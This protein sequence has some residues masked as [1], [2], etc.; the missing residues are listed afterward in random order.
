M[1]AT[2]SVPI[3]DTVDFPGSKDDIRARLFATLVDLLA[4][5]R[6]YGLARLILGNSSDAEDA[7]HDA[8]LTA[9]RRFADLR[10]PDRFEAWFGRILDQC[11]SRSATRPTPAAD[12]RDARGW[13]IARRSIERSGRRVVRH[14]V[15]RRAVRSLSAEHRE[16]VVLRYYADL[17]VDQ[18]AERTG[19]RTGTVKSLIH[20]THF[21]ECAPR[22]TPVAT[23]GPADER[24]EA[25]PAVT[26]V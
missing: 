19:T 12:Q 2:D 15:L 18:I 5:D 23:G 4:L 16:V 13:A 11:L 20:L 22:S 7:T 9:W 3:V 26:N 21:A 8:A 1:I 14:E 24:R 10:E 6:A 25:G 17:T